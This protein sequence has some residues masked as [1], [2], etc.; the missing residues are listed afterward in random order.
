MLFDVNENTKITPEMIEEHVREARRLRA[1]AVA[2][3][4]KAGVSGFAAWFARPARPAASKPAR[5]IAGK[6]AATA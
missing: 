4:V 5:A 1:E 3:G 2:R 6:G